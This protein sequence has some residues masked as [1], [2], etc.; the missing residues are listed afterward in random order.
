MKKQ[1]EQLHA[2]EEEILNENQFEDLRVTKK[3]LPPYFEN[4]SRDIMLNRKLKILLQKSKYCPMQ[5]IS[6]LERKAVSHQI[7]LSLVEEI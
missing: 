6:E 4:L 5:N 7:K 1:K 2:N 3:Q